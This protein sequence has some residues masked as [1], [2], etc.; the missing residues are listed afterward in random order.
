MVVNNFRP[1]SVLPFFSKIL[2]RLMYSRIL[3]FFNKHQLFYKY[4]FGFRE[5][6]GTDVALIILLDKIMSALNDGDY[7]LGVFLDLSKA[8]D[9]VDHSI[10]LMK[11]YKYGVRGIAYDWIISYL[12]NRKQYVSFNNCDSNTMNVSCGVPQGSILG[13]LLFLIY[14]NDLANV[15]TV[16]FT[17]LFADDTNVFITGKN[18]LNLF[19]TMNEE[20][21]KLSEWM[22][23]NK[24]SLN[25]KK[26]KYMIFSL[27]KPI[28]HY[29]SILLNGETIE[30]V[31]NFKFLGVNIDC[32]VS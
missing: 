3:S 14:V 16:L 15:S 22:N 29:G 32:Q 5:Q 9:T 8:F 30:N 19:T 27:K 1:V 12:E 21:S 13:P 10:L 28:N 20:L 23:V 26:T 7:V 24:L 11:M 17:I 31:D 2:E 18:I 4:Q 6:H 25:V